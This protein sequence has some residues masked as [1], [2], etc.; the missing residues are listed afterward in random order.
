MPTIE[1]ISLDSAR[2]DLN[3]VDFSAAIIV[4][5][6]LISHR[7][8]FYDLLL[9][10][11]GIIIH[12]GNPDMK[13]DIEAG[14]YAGKIIDWQ[15]EDTDLEEKIKGLKSNEDNCYIN[16]D[17]I[18]RFKVEY[19]GDIRR[20][21][22]SAIDSSPTNTIYFLTDYQFGPEKAT[23]QTVDSLKMFWEQHDRD[24]LAWNSLYKIKEK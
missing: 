10:Q 3:Q 4:E 22:Q 15:F 18:F 24:G 13:Q 14:F 17:F 19:Q 5:N 12:I 6:K 21:M 9:T 20:I 2:L 23:I 11:N 1:I 8:L 16:Q 7:G